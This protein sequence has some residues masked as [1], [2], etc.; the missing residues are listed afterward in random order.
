MASTPDIIMARINRNLGGPGVVVTAKDFVDVAERAAVDQALARLVR[1]GTLVRVHRGLYHL[2]RVSDKLG[3]TM[4]PDP[5]AIADAVGRQTGS[6]VAP[7]DAAVANRLGLSTQVPAKHVYLTTGRSRIMRIGRQTIR[8]KRVSA[9][10]LPRVPP[11]VMQALQALRS[12]GPNPGDAAIRAISRS[13]T[14]REREHVVRHAQYDTHW[15]AAAA[16]RLA[17]SRPKDSK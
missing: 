14:A 2:P 12:A 7:S 8:F 9:R 15:M 10:R 5:D 13:L 6:P 3:I 1:S 16:C 11:E 4:P 17:G